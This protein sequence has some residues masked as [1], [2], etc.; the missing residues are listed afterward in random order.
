MCH[1]ASSGRDEGGARLWCGHLQLRRLARC[2]S[3]RALRLECLAGTTGHD[4]GYLAKARENGAAIAS[5]IH[6]EPGLK[7]YY[8]NPSVA[9]SAVFGTSLAEHWF[10]RAHRRRQ[11]DFLVRACSVRS[12]RKAASIAI[13]TA[14]AHRRVRGRGKAGDCDALAGARSRERRV[15]GTMRHLRGTWWSG[16]RR[17]LSGRWG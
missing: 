16:P 8:G 1:A 12:S 10:R 4:Q 14:G 13:T 17:S 11:R 6:W 2:Q 3:H 15:A 5:S 9:K 7:K